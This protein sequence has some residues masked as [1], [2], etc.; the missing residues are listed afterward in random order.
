MISRANKPVEP[1]HRKLCAG[2]T[3]LPRKRTV[4]LTTT[5]DEIGH[6]ETFT[7]PKLSDMLPTC[8]ANGR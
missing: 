2:E 7:L 6:Q 5:I 8:F 4:A 1:A 3:E